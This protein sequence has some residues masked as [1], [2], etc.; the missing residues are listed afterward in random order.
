MSDK[1]EVIDVDEILSDPST[2]LVKL[3]DL[4]PEIISDF[5]EARKFFDQYRYLWANESAKKSKIKT[6][7]RKKKRVIGKEFDKKKKQWVDKEEDYLEEVL[8]RDLLNRHFPGSSIEFKQF[9]PVY[10]DV[11]K[12]DE[13]QRAL[14]VIAAIDLVVLDDFLWYYTTQILKIPKSRAPFTRKWPGLGGGL[15]HRNKQTGNLNHD[16]N[17]AKKA[18][19]E[20]VKYAINRG[21][22]LGDDTYGKEDTTTITQEQ[23]ADALEIIYSSNL[24]PDRIKAARDYL[25]DSV[26]ATIYPAFIKK[27]E[28]EIK[29]N[30][31]T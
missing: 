8:M 2:E 23:Y 21:T 18:L 22:R 5:N 26:D 3:E 10:I 29:E 30:G 12:G 15:Y 20:A 9:T 4:S 25:I 6:A 24:P 31:K 19:T 7:H 1:D 28:Q 16:S 13:A 11:G 17:P 27:L 14:L